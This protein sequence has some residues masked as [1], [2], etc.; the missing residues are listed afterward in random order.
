MAIYTTDSGFDDLIGIMMTAGDRITGYYSTKRG[1]GSPLNVAG[2]SKAL[3]CV[4]RFPGVVRPYLIRADAKGSGFDGTAKDDQGSLNDEPW[5]A[6]ATPILED[7]ISEDDL[8]KY[9]ASAEAGD[10]ES[11][12]V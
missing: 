10:R 1:L 4:V 6:T 9:F 3:N 7:D 12:K 5:T 8:D 11:S 2:G